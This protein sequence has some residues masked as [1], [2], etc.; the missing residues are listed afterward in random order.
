[1]KKLSF[2]EKITLLKGS[3]KEA[4]KRLH[5]SIQY[6]N[7]V[8][9]VIYIGV[10]FATILTIAHGLSGHWGTFECQSIFLLWMIVLLANW[11]EG[12]AIYREKIRTFQLN[13]LKLNLSAR[14]LIHGQ[15]QRV[16]ARQ[17]KEGDLVL[18]EAGDLIPS[19]GKVID[20][21]ATVDESTITG[22]SAPVIRESSPD[23]CTVIEGTRVISDRITIRITA[24]QGV[25]CLD[26]I[27]SSLT[28]TGY[29]KTRS[30]IKISLLLSVLTFLFMLG[31]ISLKFLSD[32]VSSFSNG[33]GDIFSVT[34]L[35][36]ILICFI[37]SIMGALL[38]AIGIA[39]IGR[40]FGSHV[41]ARS[42]FPVE[43]ASDIDLLILDK[44]G[45]VTLGN[46]KAVEF[47]PAPEVSEKELAEVAQLASLSDE[48]PEGRSIVILAKEK[49]DLRGQ[50]V[51]NQFVTFIPFSS[52]TRMSGIDIKNEQG[53]VIRSIRK[54]ATD[55]I[56]Q[57]VEKEG[58]TFPLL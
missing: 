51:D 26:R 10:I 5:P 28:G 32:F 21:V 42:S 45:T 43:T 47:I 35:I 50:H 24:E 15:E 41:I 23:H 16:P 22:E 54:G 25:G 9:F 36:V 6:Q 38:N 49:F 1:M 53:K 29:K 12:L 55:D 8:R 44:T 27:F 48:T 52:N 46:R 11:A 39:G 57:Y 31:I 18:C 17:L 4:L 34:T 19:D 40:L 58:G 3:F 14:L 56:Q 37:P 2:A 30:E 20:G 7:P 33:A 13:K